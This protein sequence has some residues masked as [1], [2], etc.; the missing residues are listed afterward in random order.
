[1]TRKITGT[2]KKAKSKHLYTS[3]AHSCEL[4][5]NRPYRYVVE[6]IV[7]HVVKQVD[8]LALYP[9]CHRR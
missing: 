3:T 6:K 9:P 5:T 7:A 8:S 4:I 2:K 1:M